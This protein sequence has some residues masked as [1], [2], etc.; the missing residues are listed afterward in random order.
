MKNMKIKLVVIEK[1]LTGHSSKK[2]YFRYFIDHYGKMY[3]KR[4]YNMYYTV[5]YL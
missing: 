5:L 4:V 3:Q 1:A 2:T